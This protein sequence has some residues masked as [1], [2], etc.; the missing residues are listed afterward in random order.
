VVFWGLLLVWLF[1]WSS[2]LPQALARIPPLRIREA[3]SSLADRS[4]VVLSL[5]A[6]F[7][8]V[9]FSFSTRQEYYALP[10]LPPLAL[11]VG[12]WLAEEEASPIGSRLRAFGKSSSLVL[13]VLGCLTLAVTFYLAVTL[14]SVPASTDIAELLHSGPE[15]SQQYALSLGHFRDL[16]LRVMAMFRTPLLLFGLSLFVGAGVNWYFRRRCRPDWGNWS[17]ALMSVGL[18]IAVHMALVTFSP[19]L[20]SKPLADAIARVYKPGDIIEINGEYEGG[21]TL[22]YYTGHQVRILNGR[23]ANLWYGS[24]FPD[25]P[26]IFDDTASFQRLWN[27][28]QR[29]F[30]WTEA[31]KKD[32]ALKGIN[33]TT[34]FLLAQ[35]GGK[36][37]LTN[38]AAHRADRC[39]DDRN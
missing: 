2:F 39:A 34:V 24:Q 4:K 25:A 28:P 23:S 27:G 1:P 11:L 36:L 37:I 32:E 15:E 22:N 14:P 6:L 33:G 3:I 16:N 20:T 12:S 5:C 10:A 18:L 38:R 8:L 19:I 35:S 7:V 21:S 31:E 17:L 30:L 29:V 9:F 26:Q 13:A